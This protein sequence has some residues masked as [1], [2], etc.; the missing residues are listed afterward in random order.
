MATIAQW[1]SG[2]LPASA[3][4]NPPTVSGEEISFSGPGDGYVRFDLASSL[5]ALSARY[6]LLTPTSWGSSS[7]PLLRMIF[8]GSS[9]GGQGAM[10][11]SGTPGQIRVTTASGTISAAS[12]SNT[13]ALSSL[14]RIENQFD[15]ANDAVQCRVFSGNSTTPL[16]DSG[17]ASCDLTG[18][19]TQIR[20]GRLA[21]NDTPEFRMSHFKATDQ[22]EWI[23][24]VQEPSPPTVQVWDGTQLVSATVEVWDGTQLVPA[25]IDI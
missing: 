7:T 18:P 25:T 21:N 15:S 10:S 1:D 16:W 12:P 14:Y 19:F 11:G 4:A 6:Y 20:L 17:S 23:G 22:L 24:P 9:N 3:G 13:V 8:G 5:T 2:A